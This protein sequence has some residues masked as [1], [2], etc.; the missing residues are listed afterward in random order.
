MVQLAVQ[1]GQHLLPRPANR[2]PGQGNQI[3]ITD[4]RNVIPGGQGTGHQQFGHPAK[5]VQ[6]I[7]KMTHDRRHVG[8]PASLRP[9]ISAQ[10]QLS[11]IKN[12]QATGVE[13]AQYQNREP[14]Q[15][16]TGQQS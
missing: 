9:R 7:G 4:T 2:A 8:H 11:R 12:V 14:T 3:K 5:V 6:T 13:S 10:I 15:A 16:S 1:A